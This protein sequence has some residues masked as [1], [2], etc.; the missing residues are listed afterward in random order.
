MARRIK[1][2]WPKV[3]QD[4]KESGLSQSEYCVIHKIHRKVFLRNLERFEANQE[5]VAAPSTINSKPS[6]NQDNFVE[7]KV[8]QPMPSCS[9]KIT[10][11]AGCVIEV[12]L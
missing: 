1:R 6:L 9:I 12:P 7:L 10:T 2:N 4:W 8:S 3:F 11:A 5:L